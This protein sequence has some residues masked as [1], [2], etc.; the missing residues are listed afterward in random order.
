MEGMPQSVMIQ[1]LSQAGDTES[2]SAMLDKLLEISSS[3]NE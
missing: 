3:A 1:L 2:S